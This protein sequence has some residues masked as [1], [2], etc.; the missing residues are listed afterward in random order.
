[1]VKIITNVKNSSHYIIELIDALPEFRFLEKGNSC[2]FKQRI[3]C[4]SICTKWKHCW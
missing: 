3:F 4:S 2:N 1:L